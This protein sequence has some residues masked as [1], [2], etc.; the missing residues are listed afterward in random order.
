MASDLRF[1]KEK[2]FKTRFIE[3]D[4]AFKPNIRFNKDR[5]LAGF[6]EK[7]SVI[8]LE[9][10]L[11]IRPRQMVGV[12]WMVREREFLV[13]VLKSSECRKEVWRVGI[14]DVRERVSCIESL[15]ELGLWVEAGERVLAIARNK[16]LIAG[17]GK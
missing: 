1:F 5:R 14:G 17:L 12:L 9:K 11:T 7:K 16:I 13:V 4:L 15:M 3:E 10:V 2:A 6:Y 8:L